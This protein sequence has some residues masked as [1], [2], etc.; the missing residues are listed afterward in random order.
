VWAYTYISKI[1]NARLNIPHVTSN[2]F[3]L[4]KFNLWIFWGWRQQVPPKN[5]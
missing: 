1:R 4:W 5:Q 2:I 3:I